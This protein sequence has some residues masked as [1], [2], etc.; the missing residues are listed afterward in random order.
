MYYD[1]NGKLIP[2]EIVICVAFDLNEL[3]GIAKVDK[4]YV[5]LDN[6][7]SGNYRGDETVNNNSVWINPYEY[8]NVSKDDVRK[9]TNDKSIIELA[10]EVID[11]KW[12]NGNDRKERLTKAGYNYRLVQDKVNELLSKKSVLEL[13][14]EVIVGKWGN[15]ND[16]KERLTKVG[17]NY[18]LVQDK[19]N[20]LLR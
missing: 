19:V 15:G 11:G 10:N 1:K 18:R 6:R 17:Y 9:Y 14:N 20:E 3:K 16:R 4:Y 2:S 13:A 7:E 5:H 12:G 8:F